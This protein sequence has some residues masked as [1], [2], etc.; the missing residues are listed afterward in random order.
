[1]LIARFW[2]LNG[3]RCSRPQGKQSGSQLRT[4]L[5]D[6]VSN[7]K[8]DHWPEGPTMAE[9]TSKLTMLRQ[10]RTM[11]NLGQDSISRSGQSL[12]GCHMHRPI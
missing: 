6:L 9:N 5:V 8:L 10:N 12:M 1:M 3:K 4:N 2:T 11:P 7:F